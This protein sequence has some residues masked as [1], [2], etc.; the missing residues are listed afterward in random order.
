[1]KEKTAYRVGGHVFTLMLERELSENLQLSAFEPFKI[2]DTEEPLF[3]VEVLDAISDSIIEP[4]IVDAE[5]SSSGMPKVDVYRVENGYMYNIT[6]PYNSEVNA[7]LVVDHVNCKTRVAIKG[8]RYS[9]LTGLNNAL[10]L[11]YISF[12]MQHSTLLLHAS[13]VIHEGHA[14]LFLGK[15]GT[16]KSTHSR[17]WLDAFES[18]ELLNDDHPIIRYFEDGS[19]TVYGSPWSGKTPCYRNLSAPLGAIV[20]IEQ[21]PQNSIERLRPLKA[22]ASITTSCTGAQWSKKLMN[23]KVAA[24]EKVASSSK[25]YIMRCLPNRDAAE[26]CYSSIKSDI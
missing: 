22:Y 14:Y 23:D 3:E 15:S 24:I 2:E 4:I 18:S 26:V 6:M 12:T 7:S 20:R 11:S 1:M 25:G 10:I 19:I 8:N 17:M 5:V 13:T 9:M 16:G 21:A